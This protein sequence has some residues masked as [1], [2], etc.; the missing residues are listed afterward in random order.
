MPTKNKT[1]GVDTP[2][3]AP[4]KKMATCKGD[5]PKERREIPA[6]PSYKCG[7]CKREWFGK[8]YFRTNNNRP[9]CVMCAGAGSY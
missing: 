9:K 5:I 7:D 6:A 2:P 1:A 3:A 8:I 4:T